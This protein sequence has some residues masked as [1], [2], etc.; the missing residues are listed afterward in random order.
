MASSG[1]AMPVSPLAPDQFPDLPQ[2]GGVK[3]ATACR[4]FY[5]ARGLNRDDVFLITF[6]PGTVCAGVFTRSA[7]ASADVDW[8]RAALISGKGRARALLVNAGNSNAFTGAFG[9]QKNAASLAAL[10]THLGVPAETCFLAATGVIGEPMPRADFVAELV[11][12]LAKDL[13]PPDWAA[14]AKAFMT[15][16]TYPK[17]GSHVVKVGSHV[18]RFTGI[19]KG[20]GMIAPNMSTMLAYIFTDANIAPDILQEI[21]ARVTETT[22]NCATVD[23]DTSTSDTFMVFAT[24]ASGLPA[25]RDRSDARLPAIEAGLHKVALGLAKQIVRDGEGATK[26]VTVN[27]SGTE[28]N[29]DAKSIATRIANSP[30]VK[31][32]LA[33]SDANWGRV[34]MAA[35]NAGVPFAQ[36]DLRIW[37]GDHLVAENGGRATKYDEAKASDICAQDEIEIVIE[38]GTGTGRASVYTCDLTHAYIDINGAYRT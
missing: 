15:T 7:T 34:V 5:Q 35:G 25:I 21:T 18:V 27:V 17:A 19:A 28:N 13:S 4:G 9:E 32:A 37:F 14:C 38:V 29:R 26:F 16:D 22:F 23:G 30:L 36:S 1:G 6:D 31:T 2:I 11:P 10:T 8:C 24:G 3:T 20:S 12:K 33:A